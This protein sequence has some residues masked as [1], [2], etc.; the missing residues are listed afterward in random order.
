MAYRCPECGSDDVSLRQDA[1]AEY[2][3]VDGALV[4]SDI[5]TYDTIY[6]IWCNVCDEQPEDDEVSTGQ[7]SEWEAE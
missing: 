6:A 7:L 1:T 3:Q 5:E 4:L 2:R